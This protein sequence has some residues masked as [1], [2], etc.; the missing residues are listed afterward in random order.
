[1]PLN[2]EFVDRAA[3]I[4]AT[5]TLICA[6][7]H[8]GRDATAPV[9]F[10][11]GESTR[12]VDRLT[13]LLQ[14]YDPSEFVIAGDVLHAF[15]QVP[16]T[17]EDD[18][19]EIIDAADAVGATTT[20][21]AGNHDTLLSTISPAAPVDTYRISDELLIAHGDAEPVEAGESSPASMLIIGHVHPAIVIE[22]QRHP[23]YLYNPHSVPSLLVLPA[24]NTLAPG[25]TVNGATGADLPSP[26]I[27]DL[28]RFRPI[29]RDS[30]ANDTLRFPPLGD[31][32]DLL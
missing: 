1:M 21:V 28:D 10:P 9:E 25:T 31:L 2:V 5:D 30:D 20:L 18:I 13:A 27:E 22:G 11:L 24:F 29:V 32:R 4:P 17:T 3:Y 7:T 15:E 8:L 14:Q 6:D 12:L 16:E 26:L 23:C 19:G